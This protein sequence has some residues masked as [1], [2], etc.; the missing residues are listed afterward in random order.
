M[1]QQPST[2]PGTASS[3]EIYFRLLGYVRPYWRVFAI[4]ICGMV[5]TAA[6]E[7]LFPALMKPLLDGDYKS[8][9]SSAIWIYPLAI[10]GIFLLRGVLTFVTS[11]AMSWVSNR[12]VMDMR[13]AMFRQLVC[14]PANYY[15]QRSSGALMSKVAWDVQGVSSAATSVLTVAVRDSLTLVALLSWLFWLNWKLS[16]IAIAIAPAIA[17]AVRGVSGRLRSLARDSQKTMGGMTHVLEEAIECHKVVKIFGGQTYETARFD[18]ANLALRGNAMRMTVA[19]GLTTPVV[20]ILASIALGIVIAITLWQVSQGETTLGS[21]VSFITAMLMLLAPMK[22]LTELNGALQRG[23]AAAESVFEMVD[24]PAEAEGGEAE[25]ARATG[26]LE[27]RD[28]SFTY[29]AAQKPALS[30]VSLTIRPGEMVALVGAS[31][32]G[33]TTLANLVP[34]FYHVGG[35]RILLDDVD[36]DQMRLTSLRANVALVSQEVVLFNDTVAANIAYGAMGT[37][38]TREQIEAAAKAAYAHD[39]ILAMPQGYDTLVGENGVKLSGG[40]RQRLAI[41]RAL[42]KDAPVLILDEATSALDTESERQVQA[43]LETLMK[44]RT[45]LVIAHRLSTIERADRIVV[46]RHGKVAEVG[47]HAELIAH[48]GIYAR[49]HRLQYEREED[50]E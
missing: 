45:T 38:A 9:D 32:S 19:A 22:R 35:G 48:E 15:E 3:R 26:R 24:E 23:L 40:Q 25:L 10:V 42:L 6:A 20:Q 4:A 2:R 31:G 39:F 16:L 14:L 46:L 41:A 34:R 27:F 21:F 13:M 37:R 33:K 50:A 7:P 5:V 28:V 12:V 36:I 11:Y 17:F 44:G 18:K 43:A 47:S 8:G 29:P 30:G 49:L 1:T